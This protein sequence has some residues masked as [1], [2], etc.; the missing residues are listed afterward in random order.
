MRANSPSFPLVARIFVCSSH[1]G[2]FLEAMLDLRIP[3]R[4]LLVYPPAI[5]VPVVEYFV[6]PPLVGHDLHDHPPSIDPVK[7]PSSHGLLLQSQS[8]GTN[9]LLG[10]HWCMLVCLLMSFMC[11]SDS[12]RFA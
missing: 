1:Q 6:F 2:N 3:A 4:K 12:A 8:L 11:T 10:V 5:V 7:Q 9:C